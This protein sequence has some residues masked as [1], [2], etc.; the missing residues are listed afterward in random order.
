MVDVS[1]TEVRAYL[2]AALLMST[3]DREAVVSLA[4]QV[5]LATS[6][7][8]VQAEAERIGELEARR[9]AL[10]LLDSCE[11][12]L[13]DVRTSLEVVREAFGVQVA[14]NG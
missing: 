10:D 13:E 11:Q 3:L 7:D 8:E 14:G 12:S 5:A 6:L 2:A 4:A 9:A 1:E